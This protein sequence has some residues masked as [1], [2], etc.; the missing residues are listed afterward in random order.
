MNLLFNDA[1]IIL[2]IYL[3]MIKI[4]QKI[5]QEPLVVFLL[6]GFI[7]YLYY[8]NSTEDDT[9]IQSKIEI[10]LSSYEIEVLKRNYGQEIELYIQDEQRKKVLLEESIALE[11]YKNDMQI[12]N[13]LIEKME[14]ILL[15]SVE[16]KE[17]SEV[18]LFNYYTKHIDDYSKVQSLS[19]SHIYF[20]SKV[21]NMNTLYTL[22]TYINID[23]KRTENMGDVFDGANKYEN[24]TQD[25]VKEK[26][27]K[28]FASKL[29]GLKKDTWHKGVH[30]K[31]GQHLV[32]I[33]KKTNAKPYSF[34]IVEDRVYSDY[35]QEQRD[36]IIKKAYKEI[37]Q[38]YAL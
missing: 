24:I 35:L 13:R 32:F 12:A 5:V 17:P 11:L 16:Y 6:L 37:L 9:T 23:P 30:S 27:G 15:G 29:F 8:A 26:F 33:S 10:K 18:E 14:F 34:D 28:Y 2:L 36:K 3:G 4:L 7:L 38:N 20:S 21:N 19:F 25:E 22:S 31:Y 1:F